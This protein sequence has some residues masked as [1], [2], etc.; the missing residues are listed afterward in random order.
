MSNVTY[1]FKKKLEERKVASQNLKASAS[2]LP[3]HSILSVKVSE[4]VAMLD[5]TKIDW[6]K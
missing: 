5:S 2:E 4:L 6:S 3:K 1:I